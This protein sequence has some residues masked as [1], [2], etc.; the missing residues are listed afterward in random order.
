MKR[1]AAV[2]L[3]VCL[4]LAG[5]GGAA[6][7]TQSERTVVRLGGLKGPTSMG[8]VKLLEDDAQ[9]LTV[10]DYEFTMAAMADELTP[11]L[12][13]G[14]L[15]ILAVPTNLAAILGNNTD[16]AV[17]LL[18][19]NVLGLLY[20]C[21]KGESVRTL[22]D[23]R[24]RTVYATGKGS[25][26][27]F[28][29]NYLLQSNG[30]E[31][32]RDVTVEWKSEPTEVVA[33]L[34]QAE[35]GL[36]MLPQPFVTVAQGKVGGLRIALD[37][38]EQWDALDT[39]SRLLTGALLVRSA[40]AEEHPEAV[41]AF[42]SEYAASTDFVNGHPAEAAPMV[43][44]YGI[45]TAQIAEKAIP[46]CNMV[47]IGGAEMAELCEGYFGVLYSQEPAS[48]GGKLPPRDFYYGS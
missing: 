32:G 46:L 25:M 22:S 30:L 42:L 18:A 33:L 34:S 21:E 9:G 28:A 6:E 16:G 1:I 17:K 12:L 3:A 39:G 45:V 10:N 24:G 8:M 7:Q 13:R 11:K 15:D 14:E 31:P 29:L 36:A 35:G 4:L 43:E 40:F 19:V 23:L 47:C 26:P 44:S 2:M 27:E 38:T 20:I 41:A 48:V 37:L 5:C